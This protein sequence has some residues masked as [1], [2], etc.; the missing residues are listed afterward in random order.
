[1]HFDLSAIGAWLFQTIA[2]SG[3]AILGFILLRSTAL[4]ERLFS[5]HLERKIAELKHSQNEAIE[6][7]RADLAHTGDRGRRANEKEF[8]ALSS[9]WD[10]FV[11][12]FLKANQAVVS[13]TS[14]PD[15]DALS[16]EDLAAFLETSELSAPQRNQVL[17]AAKKVDMYSKIMDL[18]RINSAGAAIFDVRLLLRRHGI[19]VQSSIIDEFKK[20]VEVLGKAQIERFVHFQHGRSGIGFDDSRRLLS[21]GEKI[22]EQLQAVVRARLLERLVMH[23]DSASARSK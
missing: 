20:A 22:F 9:I 7:L 18:R 14:L 8:D 6:A 21:E 23:A 16:S 15:L 13:F 17:G 5:H 4:G 12:A 11:D 1:V 3:V 10:S 2:A 19:F